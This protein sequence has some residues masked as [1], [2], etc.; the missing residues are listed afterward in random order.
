M[1]SQL[2]ASFTKFNTDDEAKQC[3]SN[4]D[5]KLVMKRRRAVE[6]AR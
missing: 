4:C 6:I 5:H 1:G 3:V 2:V